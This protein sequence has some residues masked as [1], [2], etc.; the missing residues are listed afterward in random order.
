MVVKAA[1]AV[2]SRP[3]LYRGVSTHRKAMKAGSLNDIRRSRVALDD[4]LNNIDY[5]TSQLKIDTSHHPFFKMLWTV[6]H[7]LNDS[8]PLLTIE[9]RR[10]ITEN[11]GF[12][13]KSLCNYHAMRDNILFDQLIV[14]INGTS[15]I[16]AS[17][18]FAQ[19]IY[20]LEDISVGYKFAT[21][22]YH[23]RETDTLMLDL[24]GI[25]SVYEQDGDGGEPLRDGKDED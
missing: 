23:N 8:S 19:K 4:T 20:N 13:P 10:A 25:N 9:A 18:V 17:Q 6:R 7:V 5:N 22:F 1:S 11:S 14:N 12:W 2:K 21:L 3:A 24:N 16:S 15:N